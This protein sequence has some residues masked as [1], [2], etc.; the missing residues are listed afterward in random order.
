MTT[1]LTPNKTREKQKWQIALRR[2]V[3]EK[4][5]NPFYA[6]YFGLDV[7]YFRRWI[8]CQFTNGLS[9]NNFGSSWQFEFAIPLTFFNFQDESDLKLAWNYLN[10]RVGLPSSKDDHPRSDLLFAKN[11]F[12]ALSQHTSLPICRDFLARIESLE[13]E[14]SLPVAQMGFLHDNALVLDQIKDFGSIEF[15]LL[16][17]GR[18]LEAITAEAAILKKLQ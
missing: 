16:N 12:T 11:Y 8:E 18:P 9:W 17:N 4:H 10:I 13:A 7:A 15:E 3:I 14:Q 5:P 2:Y 1:P 6:P